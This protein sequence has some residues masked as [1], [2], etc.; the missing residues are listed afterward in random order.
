MKAK[1]AWGPLP[2]GFPDNF[3]VQIIFTSEEEE[4]A[5]KSK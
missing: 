5:T 3:L 1:K 2:R 4:K